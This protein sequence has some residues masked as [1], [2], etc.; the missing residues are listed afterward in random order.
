MG[1]TGLVQRCRVACCFDIIIWV[2]NV[3]VKDGAMG[4]VSSMKYV[5]QDDPFVRLRPG[6]WGPTLDL[7]VRKLAI[8][9]GKAA[10]VPLFL[11]PGSR[12]L[13]RESQQCLK[14]TRRRKGRVLQSRRERRRSLRPR[15]LLRRNYWPRSCRYGPSFLPFSSG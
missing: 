12:K 15:E 8:V 9:A 5:K 2:W 14:R 11:K 7:S 10:G 3:F 13:R 1:W 6:L 4:E